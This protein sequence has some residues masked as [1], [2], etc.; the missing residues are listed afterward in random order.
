MAA[1]LLRR[2]LGSIVVLWL[3]ASA[4]FILM[5]SI[6]GGPFDS[7][8]G[9]AAAAEARLA[10]YK[11]DGSLWQQYRA[12][13]GS[14]AR[15]DLGE[16]TKHTN[17]TVA[18]LLWQKLPNSFLLGGAAFLIA[19]LGGVLLGAAAAF[20]QNSSLDRAAMVTALAAIS[21]PTFVTGPALIAVFALWLGWLP[22]GGWGRLE[23][24]ALPAV[25]LAAPY[26]AYVAR[27]MRNS[28]L[29]VLKSDFMRTAIAKGLS[30]SSA[31]AR[32]AAKVAILPV[33][34][35]LGP[36]AAHLLTG[37]MVVETVFNI[38][39]AGMVF[40]NSIQNRDVFLLGGA[41]IVYCALLLLFNL[42]V[43]LLYSVIDKRI[44]LH[45]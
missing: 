3:A 19:S 33:I 22:V 14:L 18:E 26:L 25:C 23:Q 35:F 34:T 31:L 29:D 20:R 2:L 10:R 41:V 30:R 8:K 40:V 21:I 12:Y 32:H 16:S 39:G 7:E 37:S 44:R 42:V 17:W 38:P 36:L 28:L 45:G 43:D 13:M 4:T 27:L 9:S 24:I 11:L 5:R 1:F 6:K 15:L